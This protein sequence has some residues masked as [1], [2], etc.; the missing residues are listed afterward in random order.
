MTCAK[1]YFKIHNFAKWNWLSE[2]NINWLMINS[3]WSLWHHYF[4]LHGKSTMEH[5][6]HRFLKAH[7]LSCNPNIKN[8]FQCTLPHILYN[9]IQ[10]SIVS[11]D[12]LSLRRCVWINPHFFTLSVFSFNS[13][14]LSITFMSLSPTSTHK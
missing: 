9:M 7:N 12:V 10:L 11:C 8:L 5:E 14:S 4:T 1:I 6:I 3:S 13:M 2:F